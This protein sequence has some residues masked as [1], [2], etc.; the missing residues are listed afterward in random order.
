MSPNHDFLKEKLI[1]FLEVE[2]NPIKVYVLVYLDMIL[3]K[4]FIILSDALNEGW[5]KSLRLDKI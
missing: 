2:Y 1:Y 5:L 3:L 4:T